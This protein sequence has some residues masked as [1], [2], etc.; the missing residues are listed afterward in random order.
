MKLNVKKVNQGPVL[1]KGGTVPVTSDTSC[2]YVEPNGVGSLGCA[3]NTGGGGTVTY[4]A[5][6]SSANVQYTAPCNC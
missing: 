6:G 2:G 4:G 1:A 3:T 5:T